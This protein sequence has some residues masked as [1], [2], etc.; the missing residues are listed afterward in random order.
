MPRSTFNA[1]D[2]LAMYDATHTSPFMPRRPT[3]NHV[4]TLD[5]VD[6]SVQWKCPACGFEQ[7]SLIDH[8]SPFAHPDRA[9]CVMCE[10]RFEDWM[11]VL[12]HVQWHRIQNWML[13]ESE[14]RN[15]KVT[16]KEISVSLDA[17]SAAIAGLD[18]SALN[19]LAKSLRDFK[20]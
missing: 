1:R 3:P 14:E 15:V 17:F 2:E 20:L 18:L 10:S 16:R 19:D 5:D 4:A 7:K 11:Q 6:C 13:S 9:V 8:E 12:T